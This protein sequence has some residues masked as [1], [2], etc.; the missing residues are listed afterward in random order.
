MRGEVE[1]AAVGD[2]LQLTPLLPAEPEPV[3]DVHRPLRVVGQLLLRVFVLAQVLLGQPQVRV[4][5]RPLVDPVLMPFLVGARLDEELHLHLLELPRAEDEVAGRDLVAERLADLADAERRLAA[6]GRLHVQEVREDALRGLR[7]QVVQALVGLDRTEVGLE[8]AV[9]HL[10]LGVLAAGAAV[11]A[12]HVGQVALRDLLRRALGVLLHQGVGA[13]AL[14]A[15]VALHQRVDERLDVAGGRPHLARQDDR[16]VE[17]DDVVAALHHELPPLPLDVVLELDAERPVVPS[18]P[19][20]AVDL[21]ARVHEATA[22]A[23]ADN[24]F[25]AIGWHC[26]SRG[27]ER[28]RTKRNAGARASNGRPWLICAYP[29]GMADELRGMWDFADLTATEERFRA[30]LA[31]PITD[32]HRAEVLTQLARVE[33][34]RG[35]FAVGHQMLA[36]AEALA[37]PDS[38]GRVRVF[39]ERGRLLRSSGAEQEALPLFTAAFVLAGH[40]GDDYLAVDAAHMAA[41]V[42]SS[43]EWT[44]RGVELARRSDDPEVR[45]WIGALMNNLGWALHEAGRPEE[46]LR[47]FE[48]ALEAREQVPGQPYEVEIA[49]YA[50]AKVM[51]ELGRA[52]EAAELMGRAVEWAR[53]AGVAD[54]WFHEEL[55]EDYAALGWRVEAAEQARVALGLLDANQAPGRVGRLRELAGLG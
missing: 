16:G 43:E 6:R 49:R 23:Q 12:R 53:G 7:A 29:A 18:R 8:Q 30:R 40:R 44:Q 35:D 13:E 21:T 47:A 50:V 24:G 38:A 14:V 2:A 15:G 42:D 28:E 41:L 34:L 48:Q 9:E 36:D 22:L 25:D 20:T 11:R 27:S 4:P 55:A 52:A 31:E 33:G 26:H 10:R 17:A 19:G 1:V 54:G 46:A 3:L 32:A 45:G 51:R 39:L 5:A 37:E